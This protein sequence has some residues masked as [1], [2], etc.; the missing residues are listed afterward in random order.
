MFITRECDYAVRVVRALWGESRLSVSDICEKEAITAPF[1][2]KI[3]KKLQKA[4]GYSLNRGLDELTLYEVYSAIDPDMFIIECLDPKYNCV[5]DGQD[6]LPCL[7]H[8][9]L[10]SVQDELISLLKRK[11]IQQIMEEA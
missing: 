6:G 2:Y 7:V 10:L 11:T 9:E 8:R 3:L 1:A 5:R 4:G